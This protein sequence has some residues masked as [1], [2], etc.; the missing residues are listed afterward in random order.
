MVSVWFFYM[1][2]I[3]LFNELKK[4][5]EMEETFVHSRNKKAFYRLL[6]REAKKKR[7]KRI[8]RVA[9]QDP[10]SS[11]WRKLYSSR[12]DQALIT[13]T[14]LDF[15]TFLGQAWMEFGAQ[16]TVSKSC[17]NNRAIVLSKTGITMVGHTII[18]FQMSSSSVQMEQ[19]LL[20]ATMCRVLSTIV[21]LL[22]G[23]IFT[24]D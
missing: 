19:S 2:M 23:A 11:A 14:G 20:P 10:Q 13:L 17:W 21:L 18:T 8:P 1:E 3:L 5:Q 12:S 7:D 22:N 24:K 16:W 9:L 6:T 15:E 4:E